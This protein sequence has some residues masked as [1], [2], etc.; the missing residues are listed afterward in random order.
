L[1]RDG[2]PRLTDRGEGRRLRDSGRRYRARPLLGQ[3]LLVQRPRG[4]CG[5]GVRG[6]GEGVRGA[7]EGV[8]VEQRIRFCKTSDGVRIAY[9]TVGEG[10][11]LVVLNPWVSHLQFDW[12]HPNPRRFI[13]GLAAGHLVARF[14]KRGTGLSDRDAADL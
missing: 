13:E 5:E 6:A 3:G 14:D 8:A 1:R 9:A 7:L 4:V 11:P 12:D 2:D 10:S